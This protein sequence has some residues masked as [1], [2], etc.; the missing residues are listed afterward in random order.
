MNYSFEASNELIIPRENLKNSKIDIHNKTIIIGFNEPKFKKS[1]EGLKEGD[2]DSKLN[3]RFITY[4][5]PAVEVSRMQ[6]KRSRLFIVSALNFAFRFNAENE[7]QRAIMAANNAIKLDFLKKFFE[8][9][10]PN[11]FSIIETIVAQDI[12]KVPE[13]KLLAL[14]SIIE[15][16]YPQDIQAVK[17][18]LTKFLY[19]KLFNENSY[20]KLSA[21]QKDQ[22]AKTDATDAFKYAIGH[23]FAL[24][25]INFEGN[26]IHNPNG[27]VSIGGE[28]EQVF[29]KVRDL[30]YGIIQDYAEIIFDRKIILE[31]NYRIVLQNKHKVPPPYNG[32]FEKGELFEATYENNRDLDFYDNEEKVKDQ[33]DYMYKNLITKKEYQKFWAEYKERYFNLKSRYQEAYGIGNDW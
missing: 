23:L 15:R 32:M 22:L 10:F 2:I 21:K 3:S 4:F 17:F 8:K 20:E 6:N 5:L 26:Y 31:D 29:N 12:L 25:D 11:D 28:A 33:M 18:Q 16:K 14:W 19:P 30:A 1:K 24:G 13:S 27:Y 9:F 7:K